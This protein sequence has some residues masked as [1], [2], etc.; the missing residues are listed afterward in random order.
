MP[1]A[2]LGSDPG[3]RT[4]KY[5]TYSRPSF[6]G[7]GRTTTRLIIALVAALLYAVPAAAEIFRIA[8]YN[9]SMSRKGPGLLLKDILERDAQVMAVA[10]IIRMVRPDVLLLNEV[11]HDHEN[12]ALR[13]FLDLLQESSGVLD[14]IDYPYF[15]APP[16]NAGIPSELDLNGDTLLR[17]PE[18]AYGYGNF[19]G[20]YAM[21]LVSR[22]PIGADTVDLSSLLW[23]DIPGANLPVSEDGS[24]FP[25]AEAQSVMRLSSR[26]HWAIPLERPGGGIFWAIAAHPT[27]PVF[28][29]PEDANGKRNADEIRLLAAIAEGRVPGTAAV[30]DAPVV[31]LGVLNADPND[32]DGIRAAIR[33][34]LIHPRLQDPTPASEGA[35]IAAQNQ[36][37]ANAGHRGD[38][39]FDT[40]DWRDDPGPGN[41]RADFVLP[42]RDF[43]VHD[44]GVFWPVPGTPRA[45]LL[46]HAG[47]RASDHYLVWVD[48]E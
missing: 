23:R 37:G 20:Q 40:A 19:R 39:A 41:L 43:T 14:G 11:D 3:G 28:D 10:Q 5:I 2:C 9:T 42:S 17:G 21:A 32:G 46:H 45:E 13:A 30:A 18:D 16:Q 31:I 24:P 8:T 7:P 25:S 48:L 36:A 22:F 34:L 29:G 4:E 38:P 12:R 47:E 33:S 6:R 26:A 44:A 27:P 15:F 35:R 1:R